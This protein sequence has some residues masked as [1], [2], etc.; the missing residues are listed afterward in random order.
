M[1]RNADA[2]TRESPSSMV[3]RSRPSSAL[4]NGEQTACQ[5]LLRTPAERG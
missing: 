3:C 5:M 2:G 4:R 1:V